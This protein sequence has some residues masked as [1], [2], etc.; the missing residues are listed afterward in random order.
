M[1]PQFTYGISPNTGLTATRSAKTFGF[2]ANSGNLAFAFAVRQL[3]S[4]KHFPN[5]TDA[6]VLDAMKGTAVFPAANM[7]GAHADQGGRV[8]QLA[9]LKNTHFVALGL[10]AQSDLEQAIPELS[11]GTISWLKEIDRLAPSDAPNVGVR[12]EFTKRVMDH[13]G[14]GHRAEVL[15]CPSLFINPTPNLGRIIE[16]KVIKIQWVPL[17][18]E[19]TGLTFMVLKEAFLI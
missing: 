12:G 8:K 13:Y 6:D 18:L 7:L 5:D 14:F 16:R 1:R 10:G 3:V 15:G 2:G 19:P 4:G 11:S 17:R 9:K